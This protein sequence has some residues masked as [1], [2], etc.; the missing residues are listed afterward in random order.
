MSSSDNNEV[1]SKISTFF[2]TFGILCVAIFY[3]NCAKNEFMQIDEDSLSA[4]SEPYL[5]FNEFPGNHTQIESTSLTYTLMNDL[6]S[7]V[8]QVLCGF[9]NQLQTCS[10][11]D[12]V[13]FQNLNPGTYTYMVQALDSDNQVISEISTSWVVASQTNTQDQ[14]QTFNSRDINKLDILFVIDNSYSMKEEQHKLADKLRNFTQKIKNTHW[15]IGLITTDPRPDQPAGDGKLSLFNDGYRYLSSDVH[16][17]GQ[18]ELLL[19]SEIKSI[20]IEGSGLE[21]GIRNTRRAIE[22]S[23]SGQ[24]PNKNFIRRDAAL[25]VILISDENENRSSSLNNPFELMGYVQRLNSNSPKRFQFHSITGLTD[26]VSDGCSISEVGTSYQSLSRATAGVSGNICDAN[27][28]NMLSNIG[29]IAKKL[30]YTLALRCRPLDM[31]Q[32][33]LPDIEIYNNSSR[34]SNYSLSGSN[35]VFNSALNPG[36]YEIRYSCLKEMLP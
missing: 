5:K 21:Q 33:G 26:Q 9:A 15:K 18:A 11:S 17:L 14:V 20:G 7:N 23:L 4:S 1:K 35:V 25:A 36:I 29:E 2:L 32:N 24:S 30:T 16:S 10:A 3:N 12:R 8:S 28:T 13:I 34:V 27:Y 19:Q 22:R 6:D 31:N